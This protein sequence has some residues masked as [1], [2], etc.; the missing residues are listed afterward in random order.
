[1]PADYTGAG[2]PFRLG[3]IF[4]HD[5]DF[6]ELVRSSTASLVLY[7]KQWDES[8]A[9]D[10]VHEAFLKLAEKIREGLSPHNPSSWLYSTV[11]NLAI[12]FFRSQK[13][14]QKHAEHV[15]NEKKPWFEQ[16]QSRQLDGD[17]LTAQLQKLPLK[18]REVI[19][20][21]LWGDQ[22]FREIADWTGRSFSTVR[23]QY[24]NGI[25]TL[26]ERFNHDE[27]SSTMQE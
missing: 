10:F 1:M 9:E 5:L 8:C 15:V 17:Y 25:T 12:D 23:R 4:M 26:R 27:N 13:H 14:G 3:Y 7:A 19:V 18:E 2:C 11:R 21:H 6:A 22:S 16:D 20:A 24:H